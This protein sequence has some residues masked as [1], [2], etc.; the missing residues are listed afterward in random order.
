VAYSV[1]VLDGSVPDSF[2]SAVLFIDAF[3]TA[4]NG[5]IA[6][7]VTQ[8]FATQSDAIPTPIDGQTTD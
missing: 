7:A 3:P 4:V 8:A 1:R 5:Q 2:D 6:D